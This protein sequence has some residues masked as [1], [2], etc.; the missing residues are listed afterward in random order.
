VITREFAF[1]LRGHP[2]PKGS[3]KCIGARGQVKHQLVED[4]RIGQ[5]AWREAVV[6]AARRAVLESGEAAD[7]YEPVGV[8]V[9]LT[10]ARGPSHFGTG[11]NVGFLRH[12]AP[13]HPVKKNTDDVDKLLRLVLDALT[14]AGL[15]FDDCQVVE[16][17]A[18]KAYPGPTRTQLHGGPSPPA[19][20]T[21]Y[22]PVPDALPHPGARIRVY[23]MEGA[24]SD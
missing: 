5:A 11:R 10:I 20:A 21:A 12:T 3:L 22:V 24:P 19:W 1:T 18:R 15:L 4:Y 14:D 17:T 8:E 2:A 13:R 9:T 7:Q 23:P 6:V 16:T